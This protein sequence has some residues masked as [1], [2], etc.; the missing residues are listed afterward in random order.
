MNF[1]K[2]K[3]N[4]TIEKKFTTAVRNEKKKG[5]RESTNRE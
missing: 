4:A 3:K 2:T 1:K 5:E